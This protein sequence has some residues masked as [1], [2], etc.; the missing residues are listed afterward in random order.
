VFACWGLLTLTYVDVRRWG[1]EVRSRRTANLF[2]A[3][4]KQRM[5]IYCLLSNKQEP[6][7]YMVWDANMLVIKCYDSK[8]CRQLMQLTT[9]SDEA[10][11]F[12]KGM[13]TK[14]C[15]GTE[16][17]A[18]E[19]E[20]SQWMKS[21]NVEGK[22]ATP[23]GKGKGKSKAN[24]KV[25]AVFKKPAAAIKKADSKHEDDGSGE[26]NVGMEECGESEDDDAA[27]DKEVDCEEME[28]EVDAADGGKSMLAR[29]I[30]ESPGLEASSKA[31]KRPRAA[32][33][34]TQQR[35]ARAG[36]G[37]A[38]KATS[39]AG[40]KAKAEAAPRRASFLPPIESSMFDNI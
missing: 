2:W 32:S 22:A 13:V 8:P 7:T 25:I 10:V 37:A 4:G 1:P 18:L 28:K 38:A 19:Q 12:M 34:S 20:K 5:Y 11:V 39:S 24:A 6:I 14:Y 31:R 33:G 40:S 17:P 30:P 23:K 35:V 15:G 21:S 36:H 26:V 27:V 9:T 29:D 3:H 16:K